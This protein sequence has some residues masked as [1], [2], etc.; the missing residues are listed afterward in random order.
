MIKIYE[1]Q[2]EDDVKELI[3]R[4]K[5][6]NFDDDKKIRLFNEEWDKMIEKLKTPI[7]LADES[8]KLFEILKE[9]Y[10]NNVVSH[11]GDLPETNWELDWNS[12]KDEYS[13]DQKFFDG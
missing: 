6:Q 5:Y 8:Q 3:K 1:S 13:G 4:I 12:T 9:N 7:N 10:K 11:R 2:A